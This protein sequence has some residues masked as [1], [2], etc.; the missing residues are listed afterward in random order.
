MELIGS[1][2]NCSEFNNVFNDAKISELIQFDVLRL[3]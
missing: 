3:A 2:S 1:L